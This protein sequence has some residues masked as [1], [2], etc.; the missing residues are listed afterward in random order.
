MV[1]K[2]LILQ[3]F[4]SFPDKTE[5]KFLGGL[6]AIVGPNGSGKS[7]IS[8]AIRWVL[9]EQSSRSLRGAKME[10]VI[11]GGTAKRGPV[12]FAEVSL[13]LDNSEGVFRSEFTEIM[14]TRRYYRSG[15]S[16]YFLNKKHCRLRDIHELFMDTGLGRDGYSIIGQGR[17]DEILSLKS[18]DRRE[19]FEEAAGITK[20]RY[21]KEEAEHKLAAT[22]DNLARI[23]D[24]YDELERQVGPLEKQAEKAKQFLLL[25]DELRVLEISLWLLSLDRIKA[26][27]AKLEQDTKICADQLSAAKQAQEGLYAQSEQLSADM[28]EIDREA[29]R[30]R[31]QLRETE[32]RAAEQASRAAVLKANIQN[33]KDNI[34]RAQRESAQR[35]EQAQNLGAQ[36]AERR[37]R[38]ELLDTKHAGLA[39]R[40]DDLTQQ[41]AGQSQKRGQAEAALREAVRARTEQ[42]NRLHALEIDRTAA[43]TGL[44]SMD[45]RRDTISADIETAGKRLDSEK[46]AH[47]AL[48]ARMRDCLDTLASAKNKVQGVSLKAESRRKKV[49][50]LQSELSKATAALTDAKNRVKMLSDMQ[51]D[52]EGFSRAVKSVMHQVE[53]GAMHGVHGP[54]SALIA[55]E[56]KFV[57]AI[58]TALGASAS[59]IVVDTSADGK[60]CIEYL[61]RT[62]GGRAT[63]LPIDTIRPNILRETGLETQ[64]GC[65]GTADRLVTFEKRYA[66]IVQNLLARTVVSENMDTALALARAYGHRFRIVTLDGQILQAGGA[67]TGGSASRGT[68]A[69]ARAGRLRDAQEQVKILE[70]RRA[71]AEEDFRSAKDELAALD[72]D[73][74]AIEAERI[75]AEQSEAGLRASVSQHGL[76]LESLQL[77]YDNLVLERDN[78]AAAKQ[79]YQDT[80]TQCESREAAARQAYEQTEAQVAAC[81][82]AIDKLAAEATDNTAQAAS[83][84]TEIAENRS[85]AASEARALADLEQLKAEL[86]AGV[87]GT[88]DTIAGFEA[89]IARLTEELAHAEATREDTGTVTARLNE[90]IAAQMNQRERVEGER[91][92]VDREAQGKNDEILNLEREA[93]RLENR[94]GQL[95]TEEAQILDKMWENYELTPSPAAEVARPLEDVPAARERAK[96]LRTQM[97]A[98]GNVNLDAVEE[99]RQVL[100]RY[101]FM[102]EQKD[103]LE[104][105]QKELYKVIEQ[106]TVNMKEIFA[107]AFAKLNAYFGQTFREI[108]GGGHAELSLAD[109]SDILNCGIDIRVSPPGKAV[110][111]L[112]LLSGGEKAFVAIALYFAILKLRPTPFCVLD[113]IEAALDDVNVARFAQY[114]RRLTDSTQFIV[115][116]HRRGTMEEADMLYGVTMQEQGVSRMLMLNLAEAEK[117]LGKVIR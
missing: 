107:S 40:L 53:R 64:K 117:Q 83:L 85:E 51:R 34:D 105:A 25:R 75:R 98:L 28:R 90:Q 76:L 81:R 80:I 45:G 62:D 14:V 63:F 2:S 88:T 43:E 35:A 114:I 65:F 13:I 94:A 26:D 84:Q 78:L 103:D 55:T 106:L 79:Q 5:I 17:I 100:E 116:T 70:V 20:F 111:T 95:K 30:L 82:A 112:T 39:A 59:S 109:T 67:M 22:E 10:D 92:R 68:G 16:E 110:K 47:E 77:Q 23:R 48:E 9:G 97:R 101:T 6:T 15:E 36:L 96:N 38:I 61:K 21:R 1:L 87:S 69:L 58:D 115:I 102:G 50:S 27:S 7:N 18:E 91:A 41:A 60:R 57:T 99:Y 4:K 12:G 89:E 44:A 11:F 93:A 42:Q 71:E 19:I 73:L 49:D 74:K 46:Q 104:K 32:Q 31:Q 33:N 3:G 72:Y 52:Y 8:D 66:A 24:L 86:D 108:F 29:D 113:E 54:V 56:D 37:S